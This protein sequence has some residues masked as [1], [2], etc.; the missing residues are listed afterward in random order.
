MILDIKNVAVL[1]SG[2]MGSGI[3]AQVANAGIS[4]LL[5][6]MPSAHENKKNSLAEEAIERMRSA[7]PAPFMSPEA[8]K[9]QLW[10]EIWV[11]KT[12]IG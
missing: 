7:D 5:L 1:G 9:R 10:V 12:V 2:V 4:V 3:A 8:I 6:D 11:G